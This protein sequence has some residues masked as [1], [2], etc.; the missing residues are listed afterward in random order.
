L[1]TNADFGMA[2]NH[3]GMAWMNNPINLHAGGH[4]AVN[5]R[6]VSGESQA[7]CGRVRS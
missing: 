7:G 1:L 3:M 5:I 2:C 4:P 6:V